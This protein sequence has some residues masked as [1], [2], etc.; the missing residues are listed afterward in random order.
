MALRIRHLGAALALLLALLA[1]GPARADDFPPLTGRVV[2]AAH[3][4][5]PAEISALDAKL[6]DLEIQSQRQLVVATVPSLNGTDIQDYGYRLGRA[7]GIGSKARND[8]VIL[9]VAPTER[10]VG[11]E[12]GYGLEGIIT[13][14]LSATIINQHIVPR[15]KAHDY[16]GGINAGVDDLI[17]QLR[18]PPDEARAVAEKAKAQLVRQAKPH[19][20][21]GGVVFLII[22]LVFFVLPA[23]RWLRGGGSR[24]GGGVWIIPT[25][26]WGGGGWGGGGGSGW[27]GG[28][29]GGFSG[30]GGSF[31][32]GGAS[33]DW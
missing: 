1:W 12:T 30:G 26:G 15:F 4:L 25:G 32:G 14:A 18:L 21:F 11:I 31:G 9:I 5:Q 16:A 29:D 27:G 33:G 17:T 7:W 24:Y 19:V 22:L 28:D 3:I 10:K 13:D 8:G 2:D 20:D 23:L 6:K